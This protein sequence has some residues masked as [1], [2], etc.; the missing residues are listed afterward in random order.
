MITLILFIS[1]YYCNSNSTLVI[2]FNLFHSF[3]PAWLWYKAI[4]VWRS[5]SSHDQ[6]KSVTLEVGVMNSGDHLML[7][8]LLALHQR[9]RWGILVKLKIWD[10]S[11]SYWRVTINE[12]YVTWLLNDMKQG[13]VAERNIWNS[14]ESWYRTQGSEF[15]SVS[16]FSL[17]YS[18]WRRVPCDCV[19]QLTIAWRCGECNGFTLFLVL[20]Q[21]E[22]DDENDG[23]PK[24]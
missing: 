13:G 21:Q 3:F 20:S 11:E 12:E 10:N 22:P 1:S 2:N 19:P 18:S 17:L 23:D 24:E 15:K 6:Q 7:I 16:V 8:R 4:H 14:N 9:F 5:C